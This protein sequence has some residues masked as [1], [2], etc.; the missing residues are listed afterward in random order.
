MCKN[1]TINPLLALQID[2]YQDSVQQVKE[3]LL[4]KLKQE[5]PHHYASYSK[6][7]RLFT[8]HGLELLDYDN[9]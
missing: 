8:I 5:N 4:K 6:N 2:T 3:T 1:G 9:F 7:L